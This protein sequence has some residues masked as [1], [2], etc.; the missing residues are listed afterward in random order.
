MP[1]WEDET[2]K[3]APKPGRR[4]R[5]AVSDLERRQ[6]AEKRWPEVTRLVLDGEALQVMKQHPALRSLLAHTLPAL[7]AGLV[8]TDPFPD[9]LA[10]DDMIK[11]VMVNVAKDLGSPYTPIRNRLKA[12]G[13]YASTLLYPVSYITQKS[14]PLITAATASDTHFSLPW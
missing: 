13:I 2:E 5:R 3:P 6:D 14:S 10:R 7:R 11:T 1:E 12:D 8:I 4:A 9:S